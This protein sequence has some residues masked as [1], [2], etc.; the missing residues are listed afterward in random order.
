M[1]WLDCAGRTRSARRNCQTFQV[2]R[3]HHRLAFNVVEINVR[4]VG[5]TGRALA[6][7]A[8]CLD[9]FEDCILQPISEQRHFAIFF[10]LESFHRQLCGFPE[11]DNSRDILSPRPPRALV[12]SAIEKR[13]QSRSFPD[14]QRAN[15]LRT[16]KLMPRDRKQAAADRV[17]SNW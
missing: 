4:G 9:V 3:N 17:Y 8:G 14:I 1:R 10:A 7:H 15:T 11:T 5:N 6:I 16:M 2:E 13:L 12:T